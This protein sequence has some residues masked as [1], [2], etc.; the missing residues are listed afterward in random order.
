MQIILTVHD[1]G[2]V[3]SY[4]ASRYLRSAINEADFDDRKCVLTAVSAT[5]LLSSALRT[6]MSLQSVAAAI[7][8]YF[9]KAPNRLIVLDKSVLGGPL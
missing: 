2:A 7:K 3:T 8:S 6:M 9:S 5:W 1:N 4:R